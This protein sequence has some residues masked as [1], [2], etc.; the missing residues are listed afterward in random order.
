MSTTPYRV[1]K[2]SSGYT[3]S[4]TFIVVK[5]TDGR[6][7]RVTVNPH[8]TREGAQADADELNIGALVKDY[9][10]DPRPYAERHAE[11]AAAYQAARG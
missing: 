7:Q 2:Q 5:V 9:A 4:D 1:R 8:R 11:A 10:A 6:T 3:R